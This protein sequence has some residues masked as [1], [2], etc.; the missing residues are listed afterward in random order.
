MYEFVDRVE[1]S[2]DEDGKVVTVKWV[3]IHKGS[4]EVLEI[5]LRL[6]SQELVHGERLDE[7]AG[8]P[9]TTVAKMLLPKVAMN[10]GVRCEVRLPLW[11]N[12]MPGLDRTS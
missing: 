5:R 2:R 4:A 6:M 1:A 12:A 9:S 3:R 7:L 11:Q 10:H 8:K